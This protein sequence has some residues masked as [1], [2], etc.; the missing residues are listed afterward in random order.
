MRIDRNSIAVVLVGVVL[1]ALGPV[2]PS[3]AVSLLNVALCYGTVVLGMM[4][5]MRTPSLAT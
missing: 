2:L 3:W 1:L 5:L 4:L